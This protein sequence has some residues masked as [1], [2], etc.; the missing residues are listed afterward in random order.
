MHTYKNFFLAALF[1]ILFFFISCSH[2]LFPVL[3]VNG[4]VYDDDKIQITFSAEVDEESV[5]KAVSLLEDNAA[6]G[7]YFNFSGDTVLFYPENGIKKN[8]DYDF[9]ISTACED[10]KGNSLMKD[11]NQ[12]FS[13]RDEHERPQIISITPNN[14]D[15]IDS[16]LEY[17]DITFSEAISR[18]SFVNALDISP[19]V[20]YFLDFLSDDTCVRIIPK[21]PLTLNKDYVITINTELNDLSRNSLLEDKRYMFYYNKKDILP[22]YTISVFDKDNNFITNLESEQNINDIPTNCSIKV[23]FEHKMDFSAVSAYF[24]FTP[25]VDYKII[26]DEI[27]S[28]YIIFD[29][30]DAEWNTKYDLKFLAGMPDAYGQRF[31]GIHNF[32]FTTDSELNNPPAFVEGVIMTSDGNNS[33][34]YE[35]IDFSYLS[36][37]KNYSNI[38]FADTFTAGNAI[39]TDAYLIFYTSNESEGMDLYSIRDGFSVSVTNSCCQIVIKTIDRIS[40]SELPSKILN[41]FSEEISSST[42]KVDII[43]VNLEVTNTSNSGTLHFILDSEIT[44]TLKNH[45]DRKYDLI[46]NK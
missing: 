34:L 5:Q 12:S 8:Y 19:S 33:S 25:T 41:L 32:S 28:K 44:D 31:E 11:Y 10:K 15:S 37:E 4:V 21:N 17:I 27:E 3:E 38:A 36:E 43:Y 42:R 2:Y 7:G 40:Q 16:E 23:E 39:Q 45:L 6:L 14:Q 22:A 1:L 18:D 26:K 29:I 13:T 46:L 24:S 35:T 9:C 30:K 20:D